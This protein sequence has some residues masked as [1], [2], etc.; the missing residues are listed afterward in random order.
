MAI[1]WLRKADQIHDG[2]GAPLAG[3]LLTYFDAGTSDEKT[4]YHDADETTPWDQPIELNS[5]GRP[6]DDIYVAAGDF[7]ETLTDSSA[8][9]AIT[10]DDIPGAIPQVTSSFARPQRPIVTKAAN[11]TVTVDD[12]GSLF[13]VDCTGGDVTLTLP[14]AV[15]V[16]NGTGI[17]VIHI[18]T[19]NSVILDGNGSQLIGGAT[20]YALKRRLAAVEIT[21]D[22]S[23]SW[24]N[25]GAAYVAEVTL[26]SATTVDLGTAAA[27]IIAISGTTTITGFGTSPTG[28]PRLIRFTGALTLTHN[29]TTLILPEAANITTVAGD[30]AL[31]K[32]EGSGNWRC[33]FYQQT[34]RTV[35]TQ[36]IGDNTTKPASTAFVQAAGDAGQ[37]FGLVMSNGTDATNDI[38]FTTGECRDSTNA[39]KMI[40]SSAIAGKQLDANW[41]A[42]AAAGMRNSGVAI[43][44]TTYH[45]YA[46]CKASGANPDYYAHT[47]TTVATV[48]T[49]LQAETGGSAY[50]YARRIGS[51][52][53]SGATIVAFVQ[54]GDE[55][56]W[57]VPAADALTANPGTAAITLALSVPTGVKFN[58]LFTLEIHSST[59]DLFA[60]ATSLDQTDTAPSSTVHDFFIENL[61][62]QSGSSRLNLRTN[63][64]AQIRYRLSASDADAT[65]VVT[66][67]GWIDTRGRL[68]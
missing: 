58:A 31:F 29:A 23:S 44:N 67:H 42:G 6:T 65:A 48:I 9:N 38:D 24:T 27:D 18:G 10:S 21:S 1:I 43:A 28:L 7:K 26:A 32:S 30:T 4:V 50:I 45:I 46:V 54:N 20:T 41:A 59:V 34:S 66:T 16:A 2:N 55:F 33:M 22:G 47:S 64:S 19:A 3:G 53:R 14:D 36:S 17:Q 8:S 35:A 56:L 52:V 39:V 68:A 12:I 63:T 5:A 62:V 13:V 11:Y 57:K 15:F 37:L 60:L 61:T 51:I 49:A 40:Y 25:F